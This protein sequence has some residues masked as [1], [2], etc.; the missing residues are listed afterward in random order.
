[1]V[2]ALVGGLAL[3]ISA[4]ALVVTLRILL[5]EEIAHG[6]EVRSEEVAAAVS[7]GPLP[8]GVRVEDPEDEVVQVLGP[9]GAV[10]VSSDNIA[11]RPGI[12][13]PDL[14]RS[15]EIDPP[16]G[17]YRFVAFAAAVETPNGMLTVVVARSLETVTE[18]TGLVAGLLL[19]GVP[20]LMVG[21]AATTWTLVGRALAPVEAI[22]REVDEISTSEL[23]RR[24][25]DAPSDDEIGRLAQTMNRMLDRVESGHRNQR[26]FVSDA[27]HEL[28]TPVAIIRNHAEI[29]IAHPDNASL[30]DL[31]ATVLAEGLRIQRMIE[32]LLLLARS[33]EHSLQLR[34]LPVDLDDVVFGEA[35]RLR[36]TTGL[37]IETAAV[38]A[39][40]LNGDEAA[41]HRVLRNLG[42]NAARHARS[43]VAFA[44]VES[45][46]RIDLTVDDDGPG[47]PCEERER[48][49]GRFVRLDNGRARDAG[50]SGLGLSIV[51]ELVH[52]HGGTVRVTS[53]PAGGTRI[54]L[55]FPSADGSAPSGATSHG[56]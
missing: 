29:A 10:M 4:I 45:D 52:A 14:K 56:T 7:S 31:A 54:H 23:H 3:A 28:R 41:L 20:V 43:R 36:D 51:A 13:R 39:G 44:L 35:R 46:E 26:R 40:Q 19:L 25:P 24:V 34:R 27:S 22:R 30:G 2:A 15:V 6:A 53:C 33:D 47:I 42:E 11:G 17:G 48:V 37:R 1:M 21:I 9:G 55:S 8:N 50:G 12:V 18:A 32:D 49:L 16:L 38:S 5:T